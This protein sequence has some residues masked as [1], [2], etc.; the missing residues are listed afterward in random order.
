MKFLFNVLGLIALAFGVLGVFLPLLPT[1]PFVVLASVLFAKV[2]PAM[3]QWLLKN[4][5]LG[6]YLEQYYNKTGL[7]KAYKTKTIAF[8][9]IGLVTSMLIIRIFWL[10]FLLAGIG[11]A[12]SI[13]VLLIK[14]KRN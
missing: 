14:T 6:P 13:H 12:V 4:R 5:L 3:C 1:T 2:N 8:L 7:T 10:Y 11:I 9:W